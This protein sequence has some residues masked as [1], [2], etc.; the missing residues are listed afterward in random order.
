MI[1]GDYHIMLGTRD[2]VDEYLCDVRLKP[3]YSI[4]L[5]TS[6]QWIQDEAG[7]LESSQWD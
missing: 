6:I 5:T 4:T 3:T 7:T 1:L 2:G